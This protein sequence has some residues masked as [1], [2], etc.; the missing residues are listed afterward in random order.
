MSYI[1]DKLEREEKE[2]DEIWKQAYESETPEEPAK[3]GVKEEVV[4]E[5]KE[6]TKEEVKEEVVEEVKEE[7]PVQKE[8]PKEDNWEQKYRTIEGKYRAEVPRLNS[9]VNQWKEYATSLSQRITE[10]ESAAKT[11]PTKEPA[12]DADIQALETDY[13]DFAKVLKKLQ[14]EHKAE[15][16]SLRKEIETGVTADIKSVKED[17]QVSRQDRFDLAMRSIVGSDWKEIDTDPEFIAWLNDTIPYTKITKLQYL[18]DAAR[19]FD[20][21]TVSNFFLG[22]KETKKEPV[23]EIEPDKLS[24]FTA[25][26]RS[27]GTSVPKTGGQ[28]GLTRVQYEKFMNPRYKF[29]PADWGGKTESQ[30]EALFDVAIQKGSLV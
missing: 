2:A 24:K 16:A 5:V 19:N 7:V 22:F 21:E 18:Q 27:T 20:V 14:E 23:I 1:E 17:V 30:M 12:Q 11:N 29:N 4:E 6:E 25:P 26:P 15:I 10:L 8:T 28:T 9:E 3:E 13:P